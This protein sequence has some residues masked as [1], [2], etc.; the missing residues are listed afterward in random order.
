[1]ILQRLLGW[2]PGFSGAQAVQA[3]DS[4]QEPQLTV[5]VPGFEGSVSLEQGVLLTSTP[6]DNPDAEKQDASVGDYYEISIRP[7]GENPEYP[8]QEKPSVYRVTRLLPDH[9][10]TGFAG[11][12]MF[13]PNQAKILG[14]R[15]VEEFDDG[16]PKGIFM[17]KL[18]PPHHSVMLQVHFRDADGRKTHMAVGGWVR[19]SERESPAWRAAASCPVTYF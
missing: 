8:E 11:S 2:L 1:M 17:G 15:L 16:E 9:D 10:S 6:R 19:R 13:M 3:P 7:T 4:A 12:T 5:A 18:M 14:F